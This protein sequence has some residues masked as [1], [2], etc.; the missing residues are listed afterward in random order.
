MNFLQPVANRVEIL[1]PSSISCLRS[2]DDRQL[3]LQYR[4]STPFS[5]VCDSF[6]TDSTDHVSWEQSLTPHQLAC[7]IRWM[8][9]MDLPSLQLQSCYHL[10]LRMDHITR[11]LSRWPSY[12]NLTCIH[13]R[14]IW[15]LKR[16]SRL[17]K[18]IIL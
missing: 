3:F 6:Q 12:T 8:T 7:V 9:E 18:F 15:R 14:C 16:S 1:I 11:D 13:W 5:V 2:A 10:S 17:L 4:P